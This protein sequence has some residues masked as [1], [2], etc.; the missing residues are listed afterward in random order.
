MWETDKFEWTIP[1]T[2][3]SDKS[4]RI[5]RWATSCDCLGVEPASLDLKAGETKPIKV[6]LDLAAKLDSKS[7]VTQRVT[8]NLSPVLATGKLGSSWQVCGVVKALLLNAPDLT[9]AP[10]SDSVQPPRPKQLQFAFAQPFADLA[11]ESDSP[12]VTA[13][14]PSGD[15]RTRET[16]HVELRFADSVPVGYHKFSLT[17]RGRFASPSYVFSKRID[18]LLTVVPDLQ[19]TPC[20][21]VVSGF[22][23]GAVRE[24]CVTFHSVS[25]RSLQLLGVAHH[26]RG[27]VST[28]VLSPDSLKVTV[29]PPLG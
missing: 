24:E 5:V 20:E 13:L 15:G 27:G 25:G 28:Q 14:L 1:V 7:S 23:L 6:R 29:T 8:V 2:N 26:E 19:A 11:I 9:L 17:L 21:V 3:Q 10:M 12:H 18:G 4:V 16:V 22:K